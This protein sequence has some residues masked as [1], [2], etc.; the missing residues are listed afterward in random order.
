MTTL[1][2]TTKDIA[3]LFTDE[4]GARGGTV[5]NRID[6]GQRLIA[7]ALLPMTGQVRARDLIHGGVAMRTNG[8]EIHI[9]PYLFREVCRNG[10][11]T[12]W[13]ADTARIERVDVIATDEEIASVEAALAVAI[14]ACADEEHLF[15]CVER[16][17]QSGREVLRDPRNLLITMLSEMPTAERFI[18]M[19]HE[20][21]EREGDRSRYGLMNAITAVAR[22]T[23]D[24][25]DKWRLEELG[26]GVLAM[27]AP[28][29]PAP[30]REAMLV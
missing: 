7:R 8:N 1:L 2:P 4:I 6:N 13:T 29:K 14:N 17:K 12:A 18:D 23:P 26:G 11:V 22:E 19:V 20:E 30:L 28:V 3:D 24:P 25:D 21:I 27:A 16:M 9:Y 15:D 10:A 5:T